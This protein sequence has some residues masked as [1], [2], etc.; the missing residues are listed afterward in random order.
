[1]TVLLTVIA[2]MSALI[3]MFL[4]LFVFI[5][6]LSITVFVIKRAVKLTFSEKEQEKS[7]EE[8]TA[9]LNEYFK[10][11]ASKVVSSSDKD[12]IKEL[13]LSR[14]NVKEFKCKMKEAI[15]NKETQFISE[16]VVKKMTTNYK[17]F[18]FVNLIVNDTK[19]MANDKA[20]LL[21]KY[22]DLVKE[23][24]IT[25]EEYVKE[26]WG[27]KGQSR[28]QAKA[29]LL[30]IEKNIRNDKKNNVLPFAKNFAK[31]K[32]QNVAKEMY[33]VSSKTELA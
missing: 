7:I 5:Q 15:N 12:L 6:D 30:Q 11:T 23:N 10:E 31:G 24:K 19:S 8:T 21:K 32:W 22:T 25:K 13:D 17:S 9:F 18:N 26:V 16:D 1:M 2:I 27:L 3:S 14:V 28:K 4:V 20:I 33:A 29:R